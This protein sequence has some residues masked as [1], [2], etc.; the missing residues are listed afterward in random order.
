M[1]KRK[2]K[3]GPFTRGKTEEIADHEGE[4][5]EDQPLFPTNGLPQYTLLDITD[6]VP[7]PQIPPSNGRPFTL[8]DIV[9]LTPHIYA[10]LITF[11]R[12]GASGNAAAVV[13]GI[14]ERTFY[15]WCAIGGDQMR[16]NPVPDTYFTRFY[17]DIRRAVA[18]K[19]TELE[20]EIAATDPKRWLS[21]GP[22]RI[23]GDNWNDRLPS[24]DPQS[25][26]PPTPALAIS[27]SSEES[28]ASLGKE[29][30][31][32]E[33]EFTSVRVSESLSLDALEVLEESGVVEVSRSYRSQVNKQRGSDGK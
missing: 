31:V 18:V 2:N 22:G 10:K 11:I 17:N 27:S 6:R 13:I 9:Q 4:L 28:A 24:R 16:E 26:P 7:L 14:C 29:S 23:F 1:T 15:E 3:C 33:G 8:P 21:H 32:E 25:L 12:C 19:R 5:P 30:D 20:V